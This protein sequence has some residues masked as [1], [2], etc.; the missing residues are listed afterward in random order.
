LIS[1]EL[2]I[3]LSHDVYNRRY[4]CSQDWW[5][6]YISMLRIQSDKISFSSSLF[7]YPWFQRKVIDWLITNF[8]LPGTSLV[9]LVAGLVWYTHRQ[10]SYTHALAFDYRF[11]SF[12]DGMLIKLWSL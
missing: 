6:Q 3:L 8:H 1:D 12:G 7:I 11:A 4:S 9:M 2:K 10:Q 5:D